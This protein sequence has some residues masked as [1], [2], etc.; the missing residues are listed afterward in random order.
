MSD[1]PKLFCWFCGRGE[2]EVRKLLAGMD[3]YICEQCV[4]RLQGVLRSEG[5][6]REPLF[7]FIP[8]E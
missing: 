3:V 1:D 7:P 8:H 2:H 4:W 6:E 5:I